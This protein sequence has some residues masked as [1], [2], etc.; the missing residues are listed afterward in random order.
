MTYINK[1]DKIVLNDEFFG[2]FVWFLPIKLVLL[3]PLSVNPEGRNRKEAFFEIL[4]DKAR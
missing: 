2:E 1:S 4:T 3:H